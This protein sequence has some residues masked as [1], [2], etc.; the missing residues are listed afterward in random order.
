V[1]DISLVPVA[2]GVTTDRC[3]AFRATPDDPATLQLILRAAVAEIVR[4]N[5]QNRQ[6]PTPSFWKA[7]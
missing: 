6:S 4:L 5:L 2:G 7:I 1:T 3:S